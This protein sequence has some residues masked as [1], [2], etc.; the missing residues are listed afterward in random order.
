MKTKTILLIT[1]ILL[2][3]A[4]A[5]S[6]GKTTDPAENADPAGNT[7]LIENT[8]S[9]E[10]TMVIPTDIGEGLTSFIFEV[11]DDKEDITVWKVH[12]NETTVGAAL[13]EAGLI[14]GTVSDMGLMVEYV[15]GLR[16]D[17]WRIMPG[18]HFT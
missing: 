3:L 4:A 2:L 11:K 15:D 17:L 5:C 8:D 6:R 12:T 14:Q 13:L 7:D 1:V 9:A 18:G 16:A 10:S